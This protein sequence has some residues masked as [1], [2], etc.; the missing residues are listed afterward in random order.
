MGPWAENSWG[1]LGR[2]S[3]ALFLFDVSRDKFTAGAELYGSRKI[4]TTLVPPGGE[5]K[6]SSPITHV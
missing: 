3:W 6:E 5:L 4:R 1:L 2:G